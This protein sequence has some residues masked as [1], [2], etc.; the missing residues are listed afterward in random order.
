MHETIVCDSLRGDNAKI[1]EV[2]RGNVFIRVYVPCNFSDHSLHHC[3]RVNFALAIVSAYTSCLFGSNVPR[4]AR[5][6]TVKFLQGF[7]ENVGSNQTET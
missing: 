7:A 4:G 2:S 6:R 5:F 3:L 1:I